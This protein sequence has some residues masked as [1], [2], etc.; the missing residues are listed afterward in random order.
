MIPPMLFAHAVASFEPTPSGVLRGPGSTVA[1][2][3][4]DWVVARDPSIPDTF[5]SRE[6][7]PARRVR[8]HT[9]V[10]DVDGLE[11]ATTYWYRFEADDVTSPIGCTRTLPA[12]GTDALASW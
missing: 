12:T 1:A 10:V 6:R 8:D 7:G 5:A 2:G 11:P 3:R 4:A 9:V